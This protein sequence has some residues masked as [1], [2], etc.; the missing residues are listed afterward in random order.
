MTKNKTPK[1]LEES[2]ASWLTADERSSPSDQGWE[3]YLERG[4][5]DDSLLRVVVLDALRDGWELFP[6][7]EANGSLLARGDK[8]HFVCGDALTVFK[9]EVLPEGKDLEDDAWSLS[10]DSGGGPLQEAIAY[11][12]EQESAAD[13]R[14]PN[15]SW[16]CLPTK[17]L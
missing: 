17:F 15:S 4:G 5:E 11:F 14:N 8:G 13:I 16:L 6:D 3:R 2:R 12:K 7:P 1:N 9:R 10:N